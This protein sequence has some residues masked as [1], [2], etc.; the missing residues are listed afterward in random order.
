MVHIGGTTH[1]KCC[2]RQLPLVVPDVS[3]KVGIEDGYNLSV[4][5][6][7]AGCSGGQD[8]RAAQQQE[9]S[10]QESTRSTTYVTVQDAFMSSLPNNQDGNAAAKGTWYIE[11]LPLVVPY[12]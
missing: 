5:S 3:N 2:I 8:A 7:A 10:D 12:R 6:A 1:L 4:I 9:I 11:H